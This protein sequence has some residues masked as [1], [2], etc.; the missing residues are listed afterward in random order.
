MQSGCAGFEIG[1]VVRR[2]AC[3]V[4]YQQ[5]SRC[6]ESCQDLTGSF[7]AGRGG[8]K[9]WPSRGLGTPRAAGRSGL[10]EED[11]VV[12]TINAAH[13]GQVRGRQGEL[14]AYCCSSASPIKP[15]SWIS[16]LTW[17][18]FRLS[19]AHLPRKSS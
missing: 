5:R 1:R 12:A 6:N 4:T 15:G 9:N 13:D 11:V 16:E 7:T 14:E 10:C 18:V 2:G 3:R 19:G 17:V 8:G